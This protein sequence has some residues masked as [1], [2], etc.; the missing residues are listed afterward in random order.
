MHTPVRVTIAALAVAALITGCKPPEAG[1]AGQKAEA[2]V[3]T[4]L[5]QPVGTG[6]VTTEVELIGELEGIEEVRVFAQ[7]AERIRSL[8]VRE[9]DVV[10]RGD[11]LA[12]VNADLQSAG[13]NQAQAA[14]EAAIANRDAVMDNL[15]RTRELARAGSA[16]Q[17]QL[18]TLEAQA[19]AAEAQVRQASAGLGQAATQRS[20]AVI[21]APIDGVVTQVT[22]EAGDMASPTQPLMTIVRDQRL[23]AVF[24]VP[25][26]EFFR[27]REGMKVRLQP[28]AD[29]ETVVVG[30][31]TLKG[32]VVDRM[33]RTGLM[34]VHVDNPDGAL[35][36]GTSVRGI[37]E[38]G[39]RE[40]VVLVP[41]E[42]VMLTAE[43][44]RTGMAVAFVTD[45][46]VAKRRDV[47]VGARQGGSLEIVE[48]LEPGESLVVQGAHFL[49]DG[50]PVKVA[51]QDKAKP[52]AAPDSSGAGAGS[53]R[54]NG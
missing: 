25:E 1:A 53:A 47:K 27:I 24:R 44:E 4:V 12:V 10:K 39:R 28:L 19:R 8:A 50:S 31:V 46:K 5:A 18:Q 38:L 40:N 2:A 30:E 13:V 36:A 15:N 49:R 51:N 6:D 26:R 33:T 3:R 20:R 21:R 16:T 35:I 29:E 43:T 48:G 52:A 9:G 41:A 7:V 34:E 54:E 37:V 42:A 23:K 11:V 17:S 14:L 45:G 32:P 22:V